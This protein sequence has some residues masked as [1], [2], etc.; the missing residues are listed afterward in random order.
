MPIIIREY[1][2][3]DLPAMTTIWNTIVEEANAFPQTEKLTPAEAGTFFASQDYTGV[4][5]TDNGEVLGL[6]ILHPNNIGR[7]GHIANA[8]FAVGSQARGK[9]VGELL[10]RDCLAQGKRLGFKILQF[11]AVLE[12]NTAANRL[13]E[14][15]GFHKL[16]TIPGGFRLDDGEYT[17]INLYYIELT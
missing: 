12:I 17:A 14:K 13:Y 8:S 10:V 3:S 16:G 6:Y 15:L 4:A 1:Q 5:V 9:G 11:N 7:C 2:S